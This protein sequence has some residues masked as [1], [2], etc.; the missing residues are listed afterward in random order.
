M[1]KYIPSQRI[2]LEHILTIYRNNQS[3]AE[4]FWALNELYNSNHEIHQFIK[5][6]CADRI[7]PEQ[8]IINLLKLFNTIK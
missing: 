4:Y 1:M 7:N 2:R 5:R 8:I 3:P 6:E